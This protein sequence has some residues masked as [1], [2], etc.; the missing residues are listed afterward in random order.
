[1]I[2][3]LLAATGALGLRRTLAVWFGT[4]TTWLGLTNYVTHVSSAQA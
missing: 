3:S 1:M 2:S 4:E